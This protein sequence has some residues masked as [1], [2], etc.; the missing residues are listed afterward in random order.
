[1]DAGR[2]NIDEVRAHPVFWT[3]Q[4]K[5]DLI[6]KA[7]FF[8]APGELGSTESVEIELHR[9]MPALH[10]WWATLNTAFPYLCCSN[11]LQYE[12]VYKRVRQRRYDYWGDLLRY[13]GCATKHPCGITPDVLDIFP[14]LLLGLLETMAFIVAEQLEDAV[15]GRINHFLHEHE[16]VPGLRTFF[17]YL[18][19]GFSEPTTRPTKKARWQVV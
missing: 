11:L 10:D 9:R 3:K 4:T 5:F 18:V 14:T 2:P 1:M 17:E 13:L 19:R 16:S 15:I 7:A 6:V 12:H 8:S